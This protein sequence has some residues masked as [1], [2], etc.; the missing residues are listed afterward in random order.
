MRVVRST[1]SPQRYGFLSRTIAYNVRSSRRPI[2]TLALGLPIRVMSRW[3]I[4][5]CRASH[6]HNVKAAWHN[7]QRKRRGAGFGDVAALG[8]AGGFLHVGR[9]AGPEFQ[10]VGI[11]E[12]A[13][14]VRF[15]QR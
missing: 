3:R 1:R 7:A 6:W 5:S 2:A 9:Q 8:A 15:R 13:R 4:A 12:T 14:T 10:G 11:R